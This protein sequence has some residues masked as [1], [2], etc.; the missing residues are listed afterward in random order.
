MNLFLLAVR[1]LKEMH[2]L[3]VPQGEPIS[4]SILWLVMLPHFL[5]SSL[6]LFKWKKQ[7]NNMATFSTVGTCEVAGEEK[8]GERK[9][10]LSIVFVSS[11]LKLRTSVVFF[12]FFLPMSPHLMLLFS[13]SH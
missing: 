1:K 5:R 10:L 12:Y 2:S 3:I 9:F 11:N 8:R 13:I 7:R 4:L 6:H